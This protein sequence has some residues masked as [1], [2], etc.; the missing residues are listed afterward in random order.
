MKKI[1]Y[2][3]ALLQFRLRAFSNI[4]S[5]YEQMDREGFLTGD[6]VVIVKLSDFRALMEK[7]GEQCK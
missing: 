3:E 4:E 7:A 6:E 5:I 2:V 1:P